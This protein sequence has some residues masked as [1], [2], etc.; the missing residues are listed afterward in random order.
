[1]QTPTEAERKDFFERAR[2]QAEEDYKRNNRDAGAL[3]RWGGALL[4]LANFMPGEEAS[5][6][7][8]EAVKKFHMALEIDEN[9]DDTLWCLGNAYT[10]Q[11]FLCPSKAEA[12]AIFDKAK[13]S[14]SCSPA[15][16]CMHKCM[17]SLANSITLFIFWINSC[18]SAS[19]MHWLRS[20]RTRFTRKGS[21]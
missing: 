12:L 8:N 5:G 6:H 13:V 7:V 14:L 4:E 19:M 11:G 20:L 16:C 10:S 2:K 3:T 15:T 9:K 17:H 1:M 18:R 21:R